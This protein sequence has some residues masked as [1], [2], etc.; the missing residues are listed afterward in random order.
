MMNG[1]LA[2]L[3]AA[4]M[5][6]GMPAQ[7]ASAQLKVVTSTTDLYAIAREVGGDLITASHISEGYQDPH[8]VEA[9]P[10]YILELRDADVWAFV[11]LD[12]EIGW[13][14]LL[15]RGARNQRIQPGGSGH[16]DMSTAIDVLDVAIGNVDRSQGDVHPRGNPHYWLDPTNGRRIAQVFERK[17]AQ[18]DPANA[19]AYARNR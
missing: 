2:A 13:M 10:S 14:S 19:Q 3:G 9:K 7:H 4:L 1:T 15:V 11:G 5:M 17:F 12:L 6:I 18:L 16:L 8:F